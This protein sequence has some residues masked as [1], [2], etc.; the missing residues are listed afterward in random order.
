MDVV[1]VVVVDVV[2]EG[3]AAVPKLPYPTDTIRY[4]YLV[5]AYVVVRC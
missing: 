2:V 4:E 1:A 5:T 3:A